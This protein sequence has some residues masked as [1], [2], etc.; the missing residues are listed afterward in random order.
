M[1]TQKKLVRWRILKA[2]EMRCPS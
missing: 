1:R 2:V